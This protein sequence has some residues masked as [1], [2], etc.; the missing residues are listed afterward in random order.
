VLIYLRISKTNMAIFLK[1]LTRR[2]YLV[3]IILVA[4]IGVSLFLA[5]SSKKEH[6][7]T[8]TTIPSTKEKPKTA[9]DKARS[10][11]KTEAVNNS[12]ASVSDKNVKSDSGDGL[13]TPSNSNL[14][15][16]HRPSLSGSTEEQSVCS[17]S[18]GATCYIEL[19]KDG[20]LKRLDSQ[21]TDSNG[22]AFWT[23]DIKTAGLTQGSWQVKVAATKDGL[24]KYAIDSIPLEVQP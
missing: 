9:N 20:V 10:A 2:K 14:I 24:T 23:W 5:L 17:T 22:A 19:S 3:L 4:A 13:A 1:K 15:S 18:P 11:N 6:V 12:P 16:N 8:A 7:T 21:T